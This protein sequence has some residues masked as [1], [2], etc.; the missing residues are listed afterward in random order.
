MKR[1]LSR[2]ETGFDS[3]CQIMAIIA[4][5]V[6][7]VMM[8]ITTSDVI[9]RYFFLRPV[10]GAYELVGFLLLC[11][12]T[13]GMA[14]C[15]V[16]GRHIKV[17][18]LVEKL[19]PR[20]QSIITILSH[21]IGFAVSGVMVWQVVKLGIGY[22]IEHA[23]SETL[24]MPYAPFAVILAIGMVMLAISLVKDLVHNFIS[25]RGNLRMKA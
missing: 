3:T 6:L 14:Y 15:Q 5:Y 17:T 4:A 1:L 12:A 21:F 13:W 20:I 9:G 23:S 7:F 2:I 8:L 25:L 24:G 10:K 16:Q 22:F 11:A 18:F 19:S